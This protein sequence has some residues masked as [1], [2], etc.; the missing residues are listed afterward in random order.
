MALIYRSLLELDDLTLA[1]DAPGLFRDWLV[2]KLGDDGFELPVEGEMKEIN[3]IGEVTSLAGSDGECAGYRG[4]L[5]ERRDGE[6][7]RTA[8]TAMRAP[9]GTWAWVDLE[10]WTEDPYAPT[11]L[12]IAPFLVR[13][14]L[15]E[16]NC[17]RGPIP[18]GDQPLY[19]GPNEAAS[20]RAQVVDPSRAVPII[21]VSPTREE[22]QS[23]QMEETRLRA[24]ELTQHLSGIASVA[25]LGPGGTSEFSKLMTEVGEGLDVHSGAVR[26]YRPVSGVDIS[27]RRHPFV[28]FQRIAGKPAGA[29]ARMVAAP[30]LRSATSQVPPPVWR[31]RIRSLPGFPGASGGDPELEELYATLLRVRTA[32]PPEEVT[33]L[34][35]DDARWLT[36]D[37]GPYRLCCNFADAPQPLPLDGHNEIV[38]ATGAAALRDGVVVVGPRAGALVR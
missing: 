1:E 34:H 31:A 30:L 22:R 32:L 26:T 9:E 13:I 3:G 19:V 5:F 23:G 15:R 25:V 14:L 10:R 27:P 11:W 24:F 7:L 12:P 37:R 36:V 6:Q 17:W 16:R 2:R 33:T 29:A 4:T 28:A 35:D 18:L 38:L 20:L 8:F 21:V